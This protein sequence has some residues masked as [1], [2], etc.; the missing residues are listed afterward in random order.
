MAGIAVGDALGRPVEGL[1]AVPDSYIDEIIERHSVLLYSDDTVMSI[2]LAESLLDCDGF[3]GADMA[4]RFADGWAEQPSRGYGSNIVMLFAAVRS[5]SNW[6]AAAQAQFDSG[7][8]YG[9]GGA[10]RVAPV[11]L[12]AYPDL[13][14]TIRLAAATARVTHTH[15]V[16]VEGACIQAVATHHALQDDFDQTRLL[17]DVDQLIETDRFR[18]KLDALYSCLEREDDERVRLHLGNWVAADKSVLT[19]LYAFLLGDGF[20]D[21]IR[22]AIRIGGDTDTIGAMAGALAGARYGVDSIPDPWRR[23]EGYE[24]MIELGDTLFRR[25]EQ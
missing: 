21:T 8:S 2:S 19:A 16:G 1:R 12:W 17:A 20:E 14:E 13:E 10:M 11:A 9:N 6:E 7:G 5:G 22:R 3:D 18:V 25:L 23:V 24:R 4:S 15:P